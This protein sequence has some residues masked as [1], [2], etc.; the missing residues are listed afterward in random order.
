MIRKIP[1]IIALSLAL[2]SAL[3]TSLP[4][5]QAASRDGR[6]D[7]I[8]APRWG[9]ITGEGSIQS[10]REGGTRDTTHQAPRA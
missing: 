3:A 2:V 6:G 7:E 9:D 8:Q 1:L 10:P 4:T 5:V